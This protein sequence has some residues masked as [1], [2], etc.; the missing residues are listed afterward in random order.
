MRVTFE[1]FLGARLAALS[2]YATALAG[3]PDTGADIL[4]DV[5]IKAQPRWARIAA[6]DSPEAYVRRMVINELTSARRQVAARLRREW[7]NHSA[8]PAGLDV[9]ERVAQRDALVRMIRQLPTKQRIVVVLRY[10]EDM[11]DADIA[12][13]M[14]CSL[15]TVRT[16][17]SRALATLRGIAPQP[18]LEQR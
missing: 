2:R 6:M 13:L 18:S 10:L 12:V 5:L 17:A 11:S 1:E 7:A 3:D 8:P 14:G 16:Q 9:D 4:Q 15:V